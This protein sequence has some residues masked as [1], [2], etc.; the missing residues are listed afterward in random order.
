MKD[1]LKDKFS[2]ENLLFMAGS[3]FVILLGSMARSGLQK[4]WK[5][6]KKSDPPLDPSDTD[7]PWADALLWAGLSGMTVGIVRVIGRRVSA[8]G[9]AKLVGKSSSQVDVS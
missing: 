3:V 5:K 1:Y 9:V 6:V 8:G 2:P 7:T 4:S